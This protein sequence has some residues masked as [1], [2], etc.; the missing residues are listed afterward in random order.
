[1]FYLAFRKLKIIPTNQILVLFIWILTIQTVHAKDISVVSWNL[2]H[3]GQSKSDS[4]IGVIAEI[5]QDFD[6]IAI[7]EVVGKSTGGVQ[8]VDRLKKQLEEMQP[9]AHWKYVVSGRTS[10]NPYQSERYA[11][12]WK[13][14]KVKMTSNPF[15]DKNFEA[16]IE[17]E[18]YFATFVSQ[19]DT[20]T[21][22]NFHA[23]PKKKQPETE[24]KYFKYYA[25]I[26]HDLHLIFLGDFNT[27][28]SHTVFN[29]LKKMGYLPILVNQKTTLKMKCTQ[30]ECLASEYD[31]IFYN[32][33]KIEV[34]K[35]DI[36]PFYRH[37]PDMVAARKIS[38]HVPLYMH[39]RF[40]KQKRKR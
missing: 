25:A 14:R 21:L 17:R 38:D 16:E 19:K 11:Y 7:Q 20:F 6:I 5:V 28:Q 24:I 18:P 34:T 13:E 29:P 27:P 4:I 32:S 2:Q 26:Y 3:F 23:I 36:I 35:V 8:A 22:V 10:G 1:M 31:N 37:F 9:K 30:S 39:F 12:I 40:K 33:S 15:L